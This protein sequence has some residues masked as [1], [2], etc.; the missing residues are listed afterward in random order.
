MKICEI[1]NSEKN[2]VLY[3]F[4]NRKI[5]KCCSCGLIYSDQE[6][7]HLAGYYT[8]EYSDKIL[9]DF[10]LDLSHRDYAKNMFKKVV[11]FKYSGKILDVGCGAGFFLDY[12]RRQGWETHG[13]ELT[14]NNFRYA[15]EILGLDVYNMD[16]ENLK[17]AGGYFDAVT[18]W[19]VLE[20]IKHPLIALEK[21]HNLLNNDGI[22]FLETPNVASIYHLITGK[23]WIS[24]AEFSHIYFFSPKT[25]V[26][27]L[28]KIG[29]KVMFLETDNINFFT[30]EGMRRLRI[31]NY[32]YNL[33]LIMHKLLN[34]NGAEN[35][36]NYQLKYNGLVKA[37]KIFRDLINLPSN[38]VFNRLL[39][40][41]QIRVY[42]KKL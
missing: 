16:I 14:K 1:C 37:K 33:G 40:G 10:R 41:D 15:K 30:R 31:Y 8:A 23:N 3:T 34:I 19:D 35:N 28:N 17:F 13:V 32:M 38:L 2:R 21:V 36:S 9:N 22:L 20:H 18:M 12:A 7:V 4:S 11:S 25:I 27:L 26:E 42:A 24:F 5:I 39:M 29:F 6:S